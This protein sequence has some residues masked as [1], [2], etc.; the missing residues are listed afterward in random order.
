VL[1]SL[2][3]TYDLWN[4][5]TQDATTSISFR[6]YKKVMMLGE[7]TSTFSVRV[8]DSLKAYLNAGG[9]T[10]P[11]KSKLIIFSEDIGYN[12][13]RTGSSYIDLDFVNNYLG[14]DWIADRPSS[15]ANQGLVGSHI[16]N[17][18]RDSTIGSWPDVLKMR[19]GV[20]THSLYRFRV[21]LN[22]ADSSNC[23]GTYAAKWNVAVMGDDIRSLRNAVG[24]AAG[25]PVRRFVKGA[26]D[27]VD[28][29]PVNIAGETEIPVEYKLAQNYPNPFNPSTKIS[30]ALP[31]Q[32]FVS[33]KVYDVTGKEV[34][35]LVNEVKAAGFYNIEFNASSLSSG[36]YFYRIDAGDFVQTR[37]MLLVK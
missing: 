37:K 21:H 11:T 34:A 31:K 7:G 2:G 10:V 24:G 25:S 13:G 33:L 1:N 8:K 17:G 6:G 36:V 14:F 32:G 4:R 18:L 28:N 26:L 35:K 9:T 23:I 19:T 30:F 22:N 5:G 20:G 3:V 29:V 12:Y 15:G 16:W 27:Y